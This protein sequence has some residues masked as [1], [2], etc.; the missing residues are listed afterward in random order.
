MSKCAA[1]CS[2]WREARSSREASDQ[3][4]NDPWLSAF[5]HWKLPSP[6]VAPLV[7]GELTFPFAWRSNLVVAA[8]SSLKTDERS[9]IEA[10]GYSVAILPSDPG[11]LAPPDLVALLGN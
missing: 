7:V 3:D 10:M 1:S 9:A 4:S 8:S 5:A 2:V 6:D 11:D